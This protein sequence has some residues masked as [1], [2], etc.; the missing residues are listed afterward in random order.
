LI[1]GVFYLFLGL[2]SDAT[3]NLY[4]KVMRGY[5]GNYGEVSVMRVLFVVFS[6]VLFIATGLGLDGI[7]HAEECRIGRTRQVNFN[8]APTNECYTCV[9]AVC[10]LNG[11]YRQNG[12]ATM[13]AAW[14]MIL[15]VTSISAL[16]SVVSFLY[17]LCSK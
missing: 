11:D 9:D 14:V 3:N 5:M 17:Q 7:G 13:M 1:G 15:I 10:T 2:W 12:E 16:I 6:I 8:D 4:N